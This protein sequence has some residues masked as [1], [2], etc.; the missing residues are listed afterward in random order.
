[1]NR[2]SIEVLKNIYK[3][4]KYTIQGS[5]HIL[6]STS[7]D[8]VLKEKKND[9][10]NLYQYLQSRGFSSFPNLLDDSRD[11][12]NVFEY[13]DTN[14]IP[15]E[16]KAEDFILLVASLHAKTS[17]EKNAA[18]DDFKKIYE[19]IH[20]KIEYLKY[21]Y[22][23]L[24]QDYF[25]Q[26]YPSPHAY[27]FLTHFSK[28][29][30]SLMYSEKEL[31]VWYS[32]AK[33]LKQYRVCQIHHHLSLE[34]YLCGKKEALCSW[35]HSKKDS[36]V[37]DLIEFYQQNYF[38]LNFEHLMEKYYSICPWSQEEKELF[39]TMI[40]IPFKFEEKG[41]EFEVVSNVRKVLDYVYRTEELIKAEQGKK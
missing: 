27:F 25:Q 32:H 1:M 21:Y 35:E 12:V 41:S 24:Y 36:P 7:G 34:H 30:A 31:E 5:A 29:Y 3:P 14:E 28:I 13:L 10:Q 8:V 22:D 33:E 39:Y 9:I 16:Q 37:L 18:L 38:E 2:E 17:Y 15:L 23:S 26:V 40:A 6:K 20:D 4:Y 11:G 19:L